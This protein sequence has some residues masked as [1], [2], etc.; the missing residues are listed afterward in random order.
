MMLGLALVISGGFVLA[1]SADDATAPA[2]PPENAASDQQTPATDAAT[3]PACIDDNGGDYRTHGNRI[4]FVVDLQ[5]TCD[6]RLRCEVFA[7]V[8]GARGPAQGHTVLLLGPKEKKSYAM[9]VK[10][11]GG[12]AQ[13]SHSCKAY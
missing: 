6:K 8:V 1:A 7:Y 10:M 9:R 11:A 12:T 13:V 5:N 4:D 3:Q 2:P